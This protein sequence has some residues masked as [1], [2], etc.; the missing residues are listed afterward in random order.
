MSTTASGGGGGGLNALAAAASAATKTIY[1]FKKGT[2]L[3]DDLA[4]LAT[5]MAAKTGDTYRP[6]IFNNQLIEFLRR[7]PDGKTTLLK[8]IPVPTSVTGATEIAYI[9][10]NVTY[11]ESLKKIETEYTPLTIDPLYEVLLEISMKKDLYIE[12]VEEEYTTNR[13]MFNV[14]RRRRNTL[15]RKRRKNRRSTRQN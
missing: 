2:L 14:N 15:K 1:K 3:R 11:D 4:L 6:S 9:F 12:P 8:V 5:T 10:C 13:S 7:R